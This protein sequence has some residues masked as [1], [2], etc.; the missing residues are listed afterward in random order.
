MNMKRK[1][2]V[3]IDD[4]DG[5]TLGT[6]EAMSR[7]YVY[8]FLAFLAS[9]A[10]VC[11]TPS[12]SADNRRPQIF[13][14]YGMAVEPRSGSS[15]SSSSVCPPLQQLFPLADNVGCDLRQGPAA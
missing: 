7:A 15:R 6:K 5:L 12:I 1:N 2:E 14:I 10:K 4:R 13:Y 3:R 9:V 11:L 8:A